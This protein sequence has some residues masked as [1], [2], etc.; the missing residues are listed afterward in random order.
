MSEVHIREATIDDLDDLLRLQLQLREHHR[1]LEP[2]A[3]RYRVEA[4]EWRRLLELTLGRDTETVL[5]AVVDDAIH[6][7]VKLVFAPKPWGTSCE[8]DTLVVDEAHRS[9]GVGKALVSAAEVTATE[10]GAGGM[11]A[12]VLAANDRGRGFYE[13]LGY[14][15]VSVRYSKDF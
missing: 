2:D 9:S 7:F 11:R 10:R 3:P 5:V 12:N 1:H 8:M 6:G 4:G 14:G 15:L 13:R